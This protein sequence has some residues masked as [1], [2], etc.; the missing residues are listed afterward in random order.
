MMFDHTKK[1]DSYTSFHV[2]NDYDHHHM[3]K[4]WQRRH[5]REMTIHDKPDSNAFTSSFATTNRFTRSSCSPDS[6][7]ATAY[8]THYSKRY[9]CAKLIRWTGDPVLQWFAKNIDHSKIVAYSTC[10]AMLFQDFAHHVTSFAKIITSYCCIAFGK[11]WCASNQK[12]A[13][14][15]KDHLWGGTT[16]ILRQK[17]NGFLALLFAKTRTAWLRPVSV[18]KVPTRV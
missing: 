15:H 9:I 10:A 5:Q 6:T 7:W 14:T 8:S 13:C 18:R 11:S 3:I 1:N 12:P 16:S 4:L 17:K 2:W